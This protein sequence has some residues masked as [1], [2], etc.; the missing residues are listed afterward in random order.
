[1]KIIKTVEEMKSISKQLIREGETIGFVPTMGYL[2]EGHLTLMENAK[3]ENTKVIVSIFVNPL[4]FGPNEDLETYPRDLKR[5]I[6]EAENV[7]VDYLFYP[8]VEEM[9][10]TELNIEVKVTKRTDVL[11]GKKRIGHFDG[12]ATVLIKLFSIVQPENVYFGLKDAQ[13]VAVVD[14][15]IKDFNLP[16]NLRPISTVREK[17]GLAKSSRNVY[18]TSVERTE[19]KELYQSLLFGEALIEAGERDPLFVISKIKKYLEDRVSGS[20]EYVEIYSYPEMQQQVNLEGKIILAVA[21]QY[22]KARLIDN[23]I[24]DVQPSELTGTILTGTNQV[25]GERIK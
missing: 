12:V 2:H 11:C 9:Y 19:A 22:S 25:A 17:D 18:L 6:V 24:L 16:I 23:L 4:Q 15:I 10:P 3:S 13:Q 1:M 21:V 5:D 8:S 7:G 20:V 14:S